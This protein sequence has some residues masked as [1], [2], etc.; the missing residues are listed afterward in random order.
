MTNISKETA[1][2]KISEMVLIMYIETFG[3]NKDYP[4]NYLLLLNTR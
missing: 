2:K 4:N 1:K 3:R